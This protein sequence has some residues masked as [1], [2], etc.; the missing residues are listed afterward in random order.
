V[1]RRKQGS[2]LHLAGDI[3]G[4]PL[5]LTVSAANK[6]DATMFEAGVGR[7]ASDPDAPRGAGVTEA[8]VGDG[9]QA[10]AA[11]SGW[12]LSGM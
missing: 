5:V 10:A 6:G 2:K 12:W 9:K 7:Q 4:L 8:L 11:A 3:G 1:A